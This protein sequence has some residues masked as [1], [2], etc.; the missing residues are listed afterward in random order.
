MSRTSAAQSHELVLAPGW[1]G[2]DYWRELWRYRELFYML[3]WR[4]ISVRYRQTVVGLAWAVLQPLLTMVIMT[5]VFGRL[6]NL[7]SEGAAP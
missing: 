7:S 1:K 6:A 2:S 3:A 4:D 5:L